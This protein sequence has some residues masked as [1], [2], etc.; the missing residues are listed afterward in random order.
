VNL[1][2][3]ERALR[4]GDPSGMLDAVLG[5]SGQAREGY[6]LGLAGADLPS[7]E[8]VANVAFVGMG[9]SAV[10]GDVLRVLM[11]ARLRVPIVVIRSPELPEW[12]GPHTLVVASS[13]SGDTAET[14]AGF[15]EA[16]RRGARVVAVTSGGELGRRAEAL[17]LG[18]VVVP[19]G[20]QPRAA[21]GYLAF[22]TLGALEA[23]G[24]LPPLG[25][26]VEECVAQLRAIADQMAPVVPTS[27]N[28]AKQLAEAI[29]ERVP[30]IWG[31]DGIGAVAAARWKTQMN[32]NAKV[33]AWASALPELDHNE[34]V[35]WSADRGHG[36]F[37]VVLRHEGEHPDVA[38]RF[39][40]SVAIAEQAG[41]R[42]QEVWARGRSALARLLSLVLVGD[43]TSTYLALAHEVD[44][45]PV[46]AITRLKEELAQA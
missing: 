37:L 27:I 15:E 17:A 45:T 34:V 10:S 14:L 16:I 38:A 39:P 36:T 18:R 22:G 28:P 33:P 1:L 30:V 13:Y 40:L 35:G 4:D 7:A 32:E 41:A 46:E 25:A 29:D 11:A 20:F 31:A 8:G 26:D 5:L 3:D 24:L 2:D 6:G 12:V 42:S 9:G 44:P 23:A 43:L 21:L 19:G